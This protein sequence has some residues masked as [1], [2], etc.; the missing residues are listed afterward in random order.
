MVC[1]INFSIFVYIYCNFISVSVKSLYYIISCT[2]LFLF[3]S[4]GLKLKQNDDRN[5][6]ERIEV[7]RYDLTE[8]RY[9]TTGDFAALQQ[10]N[11]NYPRETRI[12]IEDILQLGEISDPEINS[13][14]L[15]YYQDSIL[16]RIIS[17]V[18]LQYADMDDVNK[19]LTKSFR[20]LKKLIP[21]M[22]MPYVYSQIGAL[23]QSIIVVD[24]SIGIFLDK[25]LGAD[26]PLYR[27]FYTQ[28]QR[29]YMSRE[30]I[31]SDCMSFYLLSL[32]PYKLLKDNSRKSREI[33][34]SKIMWAVNTAV[35]RKV[36]D[37]KYVNKIEK[38]MSSHKSL[39]LD[40]L[41]KSDDI[42]M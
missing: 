40:E 11:T 21:D 22:K 9:L 38:Y 36:F 20:K 8:T 5:A 37:T 28:E 25:Y 13:K 6:N 2:I 31:V 41:L 17:D 29:K 4:C 16:Q 14:F 19:Q 30:Y 27:K 15:N 26:Y 34:T 32:Y 33:H 24:S 42:L 18:E 3:V 7:R 23:N 12:L 1:K 39:T 10:L 35:G